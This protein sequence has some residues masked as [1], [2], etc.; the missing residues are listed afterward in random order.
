MVE[1]EVYAAEPWATWHKEVF[2]IDL[3]AACEHP[4]HRYELEEE[5]ELRALYDFLR[6][7][8]WIV[9]LWHMQLTLLFLRE[10]QNAELPHRDSPRD[11]LV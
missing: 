8:I 10:L 9:E 1:V 5:Q 11:R 7:Q 4:V 6:N 2:L 3:A